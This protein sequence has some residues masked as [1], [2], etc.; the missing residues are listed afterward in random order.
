MSIFCFLSWRYDSKYCPTLTLMRPKLISVEVTDDLHNNILYQDSMN[1]NSINL[2]VKKIT[3]LLWSWV[4]VCSLRD[5]FLNEIILLQGL[6]FKFKKLQTLLHLTSLN[7]L[8]NAVS[9]WTS[10]YLCGMNG[11]PEDNKWSC[12]LGSS[13][14]LLIVPILHNSCYSYHIWNL[15]EKVN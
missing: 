12:S 8:D 7:M 10:T 15:F 1:S 9:N 13:Y 3:V 2:I 5:I 11:R 6:L 4:E 14:I